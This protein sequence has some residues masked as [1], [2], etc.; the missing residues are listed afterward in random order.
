MPRKKY[1]FLPGRENARVDCFA[2]HLD[3]KGR[4]ACHALS[5]IFCL[6]TRGGCSFYAKPRDARSALAAIGRKRVS[7][8]K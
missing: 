5:D 1:Y 7:K 8:P 4:P 3:S 2:F 6:K